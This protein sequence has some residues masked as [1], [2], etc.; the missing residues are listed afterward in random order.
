IHDEP[1]VQLKQPAM[2]LASEYKPKASNEVMSEEELQAAL[3]AELDA[4]LSADLDPDLSAIDE[5][6]ATDDD[7]A[8]FDLSDFENALD[9]PTTGKKGDD[10]AIDLSAADE[11]ADAMLAELGLEPTKVKEAELDLEWDP[12]EL[13]LSDFEDAFAE[14]ESHQGD[15]KPRAQANEG[16]Y[17]EIDKLLAEADATASE[18]EPYQGFSLDVGL[19]GFPEVLP[20]ST[21]FDVDADDGGVGAKLD[22]ARAYLEIDDKDSARELLQEAAEQGSDHQRAE[23]EKLLK[24]LA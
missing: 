3:F 17:V 10:H 9:E 22:L 6:G 11:S 20:E 15:V 12:N 21:G 5:V 18:P 8:S 14:V 24:R 19:D 4:D 1:K 7:L 23:A 16:G 2:D 13:A